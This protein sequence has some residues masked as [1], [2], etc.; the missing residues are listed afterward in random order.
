MLLVAG[1]PLGNLL[2]KAGVASDASTD[3]RPRSQ[4]VGARK[5]SSASPRRPVEFRGEL[6]LSARIGAAAATAALAD[7][8]AARLEHAVL[9]R[10]NAVGCGCRLAL[11]LR[12]A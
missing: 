7:R 1:V 4:L 11:A 5:S 12:S 9:Q 3:C 8:R 6:W 2:Y 10:R